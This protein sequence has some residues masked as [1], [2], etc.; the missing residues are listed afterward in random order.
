MGELRAPT[1]L[2]TR[3]RLNESNE[4]HAVV[5]IPLS[6]E[7]TA[8]RGGVLGQCDS[9][10]TDVVLHLELAGLCAHIGRASHYTAYIL[11]QPPGTQA[12][13]PVFWYLNDSETTML[14]G[15]DIVAS[16]EVE[17]GGRLVMYRILRISERTSDGTARGAAATEDL[18]SSSCTFSKVVDT[19][20][21]KN[22]AALIP[23]LSLLGDIDNNA[24]ISAPDALIRGTSTN[25]F[26]FLFPGVCV[27]GV[28]VMY[29][30]CVCLVWILSACA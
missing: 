29:A 10:S 22:G 17:N 20:L 12:T 16:N 26:L 2:G 7:L 30:W 19:F 9:G 18:L 15:V 4:V 24:I 21:S 25:S 23:S 11:G 3:P 28:C 5:S 14:P 6:M 27:R 1:A 8:Q 13:T